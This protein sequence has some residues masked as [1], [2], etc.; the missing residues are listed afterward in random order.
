MER[1]LSETD[2]PYLAPTPHRGKRNE[3]AM[4]PLIVDTK[5]LAMGVDAVAMA[6]ATEANAL[7]LFPRLAAER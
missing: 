3:S 6:A 4:M 1:L 7:R 5:A 2:A